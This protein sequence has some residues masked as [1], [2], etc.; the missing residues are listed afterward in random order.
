MPHMDWQV[1]RYIE[2]YAD[3]MRKLGT[4]DAV[5]TRKSAMYRAIAGAVN[6]GNAMDIIQKLFHCIPGLRRVD[7]EQF[8]QLIGKGCPVAEDFLKTEI[9]KLL[10][11]S[12]DCS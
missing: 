9:G 4:K 5:Y 11:P 6:G 1:D 7:V 3:A 2:I 12:D 10:E 8:E